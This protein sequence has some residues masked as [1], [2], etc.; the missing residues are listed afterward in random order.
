MD[1]DPARYHVSAYL[2][3][4]PA[5]FAEADLILCRSGASTMAELG[6]AGKASVLV[7]LPT[8][9]DDHQRRNAEV[10]SSVPELRRFCSNPT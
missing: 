5:R 4:M 7:P 8:A 1:A 9:A 3:D 6:A 2:D 10:Y